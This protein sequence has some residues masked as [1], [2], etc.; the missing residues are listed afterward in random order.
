MI[1]GLYLGIFAIVQVGMIVWIARSR[2]RERI[3]LG[4]GNSDVLE[5][6]TRVY[7]NFT[8]VV[9]PAILLMLISELGGAPLWI[10][11]WMGV[12]MILSRI[13]HA[14]G[15]IKPPGYGPY[16]MAGMLF[17]MAVLLIGAGIC[18][19]LALPQL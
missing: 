7:G 6:K 4:T 11:H 9:P 2:I 18:I 10:V 8:E 1:T 16:R 14:I 19:S 3:V 13:S 5:A 12:L 15:L 17:A